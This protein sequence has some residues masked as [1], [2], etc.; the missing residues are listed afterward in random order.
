MKSSLIYSVSKGLSYAKRDDL[1]ETKHASC[2]LC[3]GVNQRQGPRPTQPAPAAPRVC[4]AA[5]LE[6]SRGAH[7]RA[8]REEREPARLQG[9]VERCPGAPLRLSVVLELGSADAR[10][11]L[12]H[13]PILA[14]PERSRDQ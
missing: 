6:R 7:G 4:P 5:R 10:G 1:Y 3:Q 11:N 13:A 8:E 9:H 12:R 14:T 2:D